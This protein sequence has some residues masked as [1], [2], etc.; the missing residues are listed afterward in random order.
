MPGIPDFLLSGGA[1]GL[2]FQPSSGSSTGPVSNN[3][4]FGS[5]SGGDGIN[6]MHLLVVGGLILT[7]LFIVGRK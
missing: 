5:G 3:L 2:S 1:G 6:N 7:G 4:N